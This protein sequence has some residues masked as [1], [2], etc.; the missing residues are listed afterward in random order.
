[1]EI[2]IASELSGDVVAFAPGSASNKIADGYMEKMVLTE[3]TKNPQEE[4]NLVIFKET[5]PIDN[6]IS[7]LCTSMVNFDAAVGKTV[8]H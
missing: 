7:P 6:K 5:A 3:V 1:M 8:I 2:T 4:L